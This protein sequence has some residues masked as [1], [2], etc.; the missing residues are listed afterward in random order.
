MERC[1]N[2]CP[3]YHQF[4]SNNSNIDKTN[5][6]KFVQRGSYLFESL[7]VKRERKNIQKQKKRLTIPF[8]NVQRNIDSLHSLSRCSLTYATC[9]DKASQLQYLIDPLPRLKIFW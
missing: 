4:L 2:D 6:L 8:G 3:L 7:L 9:L 1:Q 5:L